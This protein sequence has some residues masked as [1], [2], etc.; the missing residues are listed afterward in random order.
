MYLQKSMAKTF[1]ALTSSGTETSKSTKYKSGEISSDF[2][3]VLMKILNKNEPEY[4]F[5]SRPKGHFIPLKKLYNKILCSFQF[6]Q[7][8]ESQLPGCG[9]IPISLHSSNNISEDGIPF[10]FSDKHFCMKISKKFVKEREKVVREYSSENIVLNIIHKELL[11]VYSE[12]KINSVDKINDK[13]NQKLSC[14]YFDP[15]LI[16]SETSQTFSGFLDLWSHKKKSD[17]IFL[18][19]KSGMGKAKIN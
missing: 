9:Q 17:K 1:W 13:R 15:K 4:L 19:G 12:M 5:K 10:F 6:K 2:S 14:C 7:F 11:T 18:F 16:L 8:K 3:K